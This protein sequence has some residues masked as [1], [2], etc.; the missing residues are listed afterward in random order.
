MTNKNEVNEIFSYISNKNCD[1]AG[2][3]LTQIYSAIYGNAEQLSGSPNVQAV[4]ASSS[5]SVS[6]AISKS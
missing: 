6:R 1:I 2:D 3:R 4:G 5:P